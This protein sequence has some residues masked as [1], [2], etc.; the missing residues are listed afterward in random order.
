MSLPRYAIYDDT[1]HQT[2][3]NYIYDLLYNISKR[4][5]EIG[6]VLSKNLDNIDRL[7]MHA[8]AEE[9]K[10]NGLSVS[11]KERYELYKEDKSKKYEAVVEEY[12]NEVSFLDILEN[13]LK[14]RLSD[15]TVKD[16]KT[17]DDTDGR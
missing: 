12:L 6:K 5:N 3:N 4:K 7:A 13:L 2:E 17:K 14:T 8:S 10:N 15:N 9:I 16:S 11:I 1:Y